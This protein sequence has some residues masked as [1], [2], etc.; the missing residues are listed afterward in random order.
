MCNGRDS[1]WFT[2]TIGGELEVCTVTTGEAAGYCKQAQNAEDGEQ[3]KDPI[4]PP[5]DS[6]R[7][8]HSR[9]ALRAKRLLEG[10]L[11]DRG[12]AE[13]RLRLGEEVRHWVDAELRAER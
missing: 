13:K 7:L 12:L 1:R 10:G 4:S 9:Q 5:F 2:A 11:Y 6:A 3:T 8:S